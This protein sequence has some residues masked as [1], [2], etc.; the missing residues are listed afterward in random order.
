MN[1]IA[2]QF[3]L[4]AILL[5]ALGLVGATPSDLDVLLKSVKEIIAP[6]CG[7]GPVAVF[8]DKAFPVVSSWR[9]ACQTQMWSS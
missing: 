4:A 8:G 9:K 5:A 3:V 2:K 1:N 7:V 6:G